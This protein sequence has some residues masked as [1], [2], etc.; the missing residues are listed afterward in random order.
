MVRVERRGVPA[1][2]V[3]VKPIGVPVRPRVV[4]CVVP[5]L[6]QPVAR[7]HMATVGGYGGEV[8][9]VEGGGGGVGFP[10]FGIFRGGWDFDLGAGGGGDGCSE[11]G[12]W[13]GDGHA[14]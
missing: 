8:V 3:R 1:V 11:G 14:A 7:V 2:G 9:G 10:A 12:G 5:V 4:V 6:R 13:R